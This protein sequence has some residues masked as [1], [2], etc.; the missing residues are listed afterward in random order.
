MIRGKINDKLEINSSMKEIKNDQDKISSRAFNVLMNHWWLRHLLFWTFV[1]LYIA[2]GY[3]F[4]KY[5]FIE[6]LVSSMAY[7]PGHLLIVY[8]LLYLLIPNF[9]VK[10]KFIL[11][12]GGFLLTLIAA[13]YISEFIAVQTGT[14][15]LFRGFQRRVGHFIT[16]FINI[17]SIAASI[18][19]I[20]YFY[21]QE[22]KALIAKKEQTQAELELLKS[23][24]H[25]HF[26]FN[27]LN[28]LFAHT[29]R[30]SPESPKIVV[31]LSDLLR[32]M[33]YE[34]RVELIP[35]DQEIKLLNNYIGLEKLRYGD[36]LDVSFTYSG[37]IEN[38]LIRPLLLLPLVENSFKQ[39]VSQQLEQKWISLDIHVEGNDLKFKL[40]NSNDDEKDANHSFMP[41]EEA[42]VGNVKR[43]LE[44]LYPRQHT[45][46]FRT[47]PGMKFI[48]LDLTLMENS[49]RELNKA[50]G[51]QEDLVMAA[52]G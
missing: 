31:G 29:L 44:L 48:S 33:I 20:K 12:F 22:K 9:L 8:P 10:R 42:G 41:K 30:K 50:L 25:P 35:L 24:V 46:M 28:S 5:T 37:D 17:S 52:A 11:F 36:E 13:K 34:S 32:F 49:T 27:T 3:G 15:H 40:S 4:E 45:L 6:A 18:K 19:L 43:R 47:E 39:G 7:L 14:N 51:Q 21:F 2:W 38:K 23:Q 16:P 1:V 26:L